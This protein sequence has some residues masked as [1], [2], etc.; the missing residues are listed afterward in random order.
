MA[1]P[2]AA[3]PLDDVVAAV[4]ADQVVGEQIVGLCGRPRRSR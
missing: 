4:E 2:K 1:T 3:K